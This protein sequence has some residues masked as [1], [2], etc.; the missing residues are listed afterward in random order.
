MAKML[1][2]TRIVRGWGEEPLSL[3]SCHFENCARDCHRPRKVS[4]KLM[5]ED[6]SM[7]SEYVPD[8]MEWSVSVGS[9]RNGPV[10]TSK[11][12]FI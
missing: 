5:V 9:N 8:Q 1:R 11:R 7:S 3:S 2:L 12:N 6:G 4:R 10:S